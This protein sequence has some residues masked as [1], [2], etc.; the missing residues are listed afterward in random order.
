[1]IYTND[2]PVMIDQLK[3]FADYVLGHAQ[4]KVDEN[5]PSKG[6]HT[7]TCLFCDGVEVSDD[8][9]LIGIDIPHKEDCLSIMAKAVREKHG[10]HQCLSHDYEQVC[11]TDV[12]QC[13]K[14]YHTVRMLEI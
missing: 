11:E 7:C 4:I 5:V 12:H 1:M 8:R 6:M 9:M 13:N 14:C 3:S 10:T 2:I